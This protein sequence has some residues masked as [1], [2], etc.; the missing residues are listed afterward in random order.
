MPILEIK[1]LG[2]ET[3]DILSNC[4]LETLHENNIQNKLIALCANNTTVNS[5]AS[6][7]TTYFQKYN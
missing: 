4:I 5:G 1:E 6:K 7:T 3:S 2:G